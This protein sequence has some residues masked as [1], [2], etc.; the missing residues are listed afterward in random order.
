MRI[1]RIRKLK[2]FEILLNLWIG[3]FLKFWELAKFPNWTVFEILGIYRIFKMDN[4]GNFSIF[5]T[6]QFWKFVNLRH[7]RILKIS[8]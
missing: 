4:F 5:Q 8:V 7:F 2:N 3:H 1:G 6:C